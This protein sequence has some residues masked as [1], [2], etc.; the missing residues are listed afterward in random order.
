[1]KILLQI[2]LIIPF[3]LML[4]HPSP[5]TGANST[6]KADSL[7]LALKEI[8]TPTEKITLL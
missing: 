2:H 3:L 5:V 4:Q 8:K 6:H 7:E 1:V